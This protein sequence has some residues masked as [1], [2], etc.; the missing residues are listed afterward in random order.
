MRT[1]GTVTLT[2]AAVAL[3]VATAA[4]SVAA[5]PTSVYSRIDIDSCSIFRRDRETGSAS[6]FCPAIPN[7]ALWVAEDDA[8]FFV[9]F[10][11]AAEMQIAAEQTLPPFNR[12]NDTLEWRLA[13]NGEP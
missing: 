3:A 6:W 2:A 5:E 11:P 10:G 4:A 12:I 8:R 9:S 7:Q 1:G 13:D